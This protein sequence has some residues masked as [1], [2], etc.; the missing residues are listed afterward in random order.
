VRLYRQSHGNICFVETHGVRL[1]NARRLYQTHGRASLQ[2]IPLIN[3][4]SCVGT[5]MICESHGVR[6][7]NL[8]F[9]LRPS[10]DHRSYFSVFSPRKHEQTS[11]EHR[12]MVVSGTT[13]GTGS[14]VD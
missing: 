6:L 11:C 4:G 7:P 5:N 2:D 10:L 12:A 9:F 3:Y 14:G 1:P 13:M 8:V